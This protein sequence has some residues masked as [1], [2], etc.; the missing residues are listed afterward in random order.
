MLNEVKAVFGGRK[1]TE[2]APLYQYDYGQ[3]LVVYGPSLPGSY[4]VHFSNDKT[5]G[6]AK[7][8]IGDSTG[9]RIPDEYLI[10]GADIFAW[11][12]VHEGNSDGETKYIIKIP[13]KKRARPSDD[14]PTPED[15]SVITQ[16]IA[17]L[18]GAVERAQESAESAEESAQ[19]AEDA[20][21]SIDK[22]AIEEAVV[23]YLD[24]HPVTV[25]ETD[26]TVPA[27]A[28]QPTKPS[29]TAE[30]VGALST[31]ALSDAIDT[32][33]AEAKASGEF[34]GEDGA[35][36]APGAKGDKGDKGDTGDTG[37]TGPQGPKGDTGETG[38]QG[39]KGD[40]GETG[41]QGPQGETGPAG[42]TGATGATGPAGADGRT[43]VKG[44]DYWTAAD[45]ADIVQDVVDEITKSVTV[46][47]T[48]PTITAQQ[49]TRYVC[50]EVT[51]LSF[52]PCASGICDVRFTSGSAV[53]VLTIP[54]TVKFPDWFDPTS[55][56]TNTVYE[57]NVMDGVYGAVMTW[58]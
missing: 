15:Q 23:E 54:S 22:D 37:A 33:L 43:P 48:S 7:T 32:A 41:P 45:K 28:K 1:E 12:F 58:T 3:R 8:Q 36:G 46:S 55:L 4:E 25:D 16:A 42:A 39:P 53:T 11:I 31:S 20:A 17:A 29:Y 56:D 27:W 52:M 47:G 18:S 30:E 6:A 2:T 44:V 9:V 24:E 40:P 19:R 49:N 14:P 21:K 34:D 38:P 50:G 13:V 35:P 51:S 57:I 26:P 10:S 5:A